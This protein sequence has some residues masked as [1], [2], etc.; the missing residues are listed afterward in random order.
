MTPLTD[1][2]VVEIAEAVVLAPLH[3][4]AIS[5]FEAELI[6]EIGRRFRDHGRDAVITP[7]ERPVLAD[8]ARALRVAEVAGLEG[9]AFLPRAAAVVRPRFA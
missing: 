7:A 2:D 9:G 8:A 6:G 3:P 5:A 1:R 4:A